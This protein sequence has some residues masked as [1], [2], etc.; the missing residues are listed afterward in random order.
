[1][2]VHTL[3]TGHPEEGDR[4]IELLQVPRFALVDR[5]EVVQFTVVEEGAPLSA[6]PMPPST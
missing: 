6:A 3:L 4:R 5:R 1:V 2:P